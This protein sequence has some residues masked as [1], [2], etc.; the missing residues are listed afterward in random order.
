MSNSTNPL[1][2]PAGTKRGPADYFTGTAWVTMLAGE[3]PTD[4][5]VGDVTFEPGVR[6]NWHSHPAGQILVVTAGVGYYQEKGQPARRLRAGD[7]VSIAPGVVHWHGAAPDSLFTH[8]AINP[9]VSKGVANW[10]EPV[11]DEEYRAAQG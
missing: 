5:T 4:C 8:L 3:N 11:T 7:A 1:Q 9:N 2:A 6:N 10:L